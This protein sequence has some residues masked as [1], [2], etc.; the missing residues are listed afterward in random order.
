MPHYTIHI[1]SADM[2][3]PHRALR[4]VVEAALRP[5]VARAGLELNLVSIPAGRSEQTTPDVSVQLSRDLRGVGS[6][7]RVLAE[8]SGAVLVGAILNMR[9][10]GG[11]Q[12][13]PACAMDM[14][15]PMYRTPFQV[16]TT[17][18]DSM[19][20]L[21]TRGEP[22]FARTVGNIVVHELGH[23]IAGL[24]HHPDP[25]NFMFTG[26]SIDRV[27]GPEFRTR[28]NLRRLWSGP[29]ELRPFQQARMV[30]AIRARELRGF[31]V[32]ELRAAP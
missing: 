10:G 5:L 24:A 9:V 23:T 11:V 2:V 25:R 21:W 28:E 19:E 30:E 29:H 27:L 13:G 26:A 31:D 6:R 16:W 4:G 32:V 3:E 1:L 7:D 14:D 18:A 12:R 8:Q 15:A 20:P 17:H 22:A